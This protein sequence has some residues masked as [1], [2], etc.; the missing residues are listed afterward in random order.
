MH[1][2]TFDPH[3][4]TRTH[5]PFSLVEVPHGVTVGAKFMTHVLLHTLLRVRDERMI[6]LRD[7]LLRNILDGIQALAKPAAAACGEDLKS[8][9]TPRGTRGGPLGRSNERQAAAKCYTK[10]LPCAEKLVPGD[11]STP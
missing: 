6:V 2:G 10:D 4:R 3:T 11:H 7:R 5:A 1:K 9:R 8:G